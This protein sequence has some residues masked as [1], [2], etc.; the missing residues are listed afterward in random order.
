[1]TSPEALAGASLLHDDSIRHLPDVPGWADWLAAAGAT[2]V[3]PLPRAAV[4]PR[5]TRARCGGGGRLAR[6]FARQSL[7]AG[8][9]TASVGWSRHSR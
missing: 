5:R 6:C 1:M 7:A 3:D 9:I 4:Q 8:D 2:S